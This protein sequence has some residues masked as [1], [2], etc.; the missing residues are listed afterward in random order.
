[1]IE[2]MEEFNKCIA[3]T[4]YKKVDVRDPEEFLQEVKGTVAPV[5]VQVFDAALVADWEHLFFAALNALTAFRNR[6]NMTRNLQTEILLY[7]SAQ[8]QIRK[9]AETLGVKHGLSDIAVV[10]VAETKNH[11]E[12]ALVKLSQI[13]SQKEDDEVLRLDNEKS[14]KIRQV[15][16]ISGEELASRIEV[17]PEVE[18]LKNLVIERMALLSIKR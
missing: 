4:G 13:L 7:A 14:R 8:R 5:T 1:L 3:I 12:E 6:V 16:E 17:D 9:A 10:L 15:F 18:A 2:K 11:V